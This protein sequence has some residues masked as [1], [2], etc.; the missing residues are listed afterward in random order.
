MWY[1]RIFLGCLEHTVPAYPEVL[2]V[3]AL[4]HGGDGDDG[5]HHHQEGGHNDP[6][7]LVEERQVRPPVPHQTLV[8]VQDHEGAE[9]EAEKQ[10]QFGGKII[11]N[12]LPEE[13]GG[14][15][16]VGDGVASMDEHS[17]EETAVRGGGRQENQP[18]VGEEG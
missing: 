16:G 2:G 17:T 10:I 3:G 18:G 12:K 6:V 8:R 13:Q 15:V 7:E 1:R 4:D 9:D 14:G 11:E 5:V